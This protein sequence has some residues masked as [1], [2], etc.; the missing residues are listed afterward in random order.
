M[1]LVG[2]KSYGQ[3]NADSISIKENRRRKFISIKLALRFM[4][5]QF[6]MFGSSFFF[7]SHVAGFYAHLR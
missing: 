1:P 4:L 7:S 5:P 6:G 2:W 3:T